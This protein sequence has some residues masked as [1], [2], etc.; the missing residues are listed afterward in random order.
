MILPKDSPI[1]LFVPM[2]DDEIKLAP[3][4]LKPTRINNYTHL[5]ALMKMKQEKY[6]AYSHGPISTTFSRILGRAKENLDLD[7]VLDG[8]LHEKLVKH[9]ERYEE[10][11][12]KSLHELVDAKIKELKIENDQRV[13]ANRIGNITDN[14]QHL[15]QK[16]TRSTFRDDLLFDI[17]TFI[18]QKT[19][20]LEFLQ[21]SYLKYIAKFVSQ[22]SQEAIHLELT[23]KIPDDADI[24]DIVKSFVKLRFSS[25]EYR[26][27]VYETRSLWAE[28]F[29]LLRIG[30]HDLA[31]ELL[32]EYEMFFESAAQKFK[33]VF[34]GYLAGKR[35]GFVLNTR[36]QDRFKKFLFELVDE[37]AKSDGFVISTAEDY[38]W[39]RLL[40]KKSIEILQFENPRVQFMVAIFLG[41]YRA[42]ADVLLKADF[43]VVPKFFLLRE[44]CVE[45]SLLTDKDGISY[46][47][48]AED[49]RI[50]STF[51][52]F[53]FNIASRLTSAEHKVKLIEMLKGTNEYYNVIPQYV[54]KFELYDIL[55]KLGSKETDVSFTLDSRISQEVLNRL[56]N[57]GNNSKLVK[58]HMI[59][60]DLTMIQILKQAV[61]EAIMVGEQVDTNIVE[62]YEKAN[63]SRECDELS[64]VYGFYKFDRSPSLATLRQTILVDK[65]VDMRPFKYVVEKIFTKAVEIAKNESDVLLAKHLFMLCGALD[66]NE[67]CAA[68]ISR[69]LVQFV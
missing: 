69:D 60:D 13:Y 47:S 16:P 36:V 7:A 1:A 15:L 59:V 3:L 52:N 24:K 8:F 11:T 42:A 46:M 64:A 30:R 66:L 65:N 45:Q 48:K 28:L 2:E 32:S 40:Q 6:S 5:I 33:S 43:G 34:S 39:L 57:S 41:N 21:D 18:N 37:K 68:R 51:L 9:A 53:L 61:E 26:I 49:Q 54:I 17:Y 12:M 55:G 67:E 35:P 56:K 58:M 20:P 14:E 62:K 44:I 19:E 31:Q 38:I 50:S 22:S 4:V 23:K 27:E 63:F 10:S 25:E 29:V